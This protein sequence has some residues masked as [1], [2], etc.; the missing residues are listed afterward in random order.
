MEPT[1]SAPVRIDRAEFLAVTQAG[2]AVYFLTLAGWS[3][4]SGDP[5]PAIGGLLAAGAIAAVTAGY[6]Y[7][8]PDSV[9]RGTEPAPRRWFEVAG[10]VAAALVLAFV[11][12]FLFTEGI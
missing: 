6:A 10:V 3:L 4:V 1:E 8:R 12:G 5:S 9:D 11:F 7:Y 2:L